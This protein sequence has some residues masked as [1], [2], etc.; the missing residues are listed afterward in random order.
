VHLL[1]AGPTL[2]AER[3]PQ[4]T[5]CVPPRIG[6]RSSRNDASASMALRMRSSP[7][8]HEATPRHGMPHD[9][10]GCLCISFDCGLLQ[11]SVVIGA[12]LISFCAI[13]KLQL[14]KYVRAWS[15]SDFTL[16]LETKLDL[17]RFIGPIQST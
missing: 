12:R 11:L 2:S 6:T 4:A 7:Q 1:V 8:I 10:D 9:S 14:F 3:N 17:Q 13:Q 5:V 16:A 15:S